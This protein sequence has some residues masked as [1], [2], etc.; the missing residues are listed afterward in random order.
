M[1]EKNG[2]STISALI[3]AGGLGTRLRSSFATGPKSLAPVVGRPFLDYLLRWLQSSG[4]TEV[5]LCVGY[6]ALQI[7]R[8]YQT[9]RDW[10]LRISYA[11]E[12]QPLG[13]AGALKN[14]EPLV[15]SNSFLV[16]NGDSFVD[17]SLQELIRFHRK[18][19]G[20]AT[21]TLTTVSKPSRYGSVR[22][23]SRSEIL[24]FVEKAS[25]DGKNGRAGS[26]WINGGAYVLEKNLM[27]MIPTDRSV[28][29]ES[30]VFPRLVGHRFYGFTSESYFID[31]GVPADFRRAQKDFRGRFLR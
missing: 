31:I 7:Q 5:V 16:L 25:A 20:L 24:G 26:T 28:S 21:L 30:E 11:V 15:R 14:A 8:R 27:R 18:K 2:P 29:L 22:V 1:A 19:K 12:K 4:F 17:I 10:G 6:K 9:G 13:T 23:N 3:L